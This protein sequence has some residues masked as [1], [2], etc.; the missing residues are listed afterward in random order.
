MAK[1][2]SRRDFLKGRSAADAL[3]DA[4]DEAFPAE[5]PLAS[6]TAPQGQ[7][8]LVQVSRRAMASDFVVFLNAGQY[9]EGTE[10]A[11]E[12]L[13][14]VDELEA[15]LSYFRPDSQLSRVNRWAAD[16]PVPVGARLFELLELAA[17][18][19]RQT[20]G[21]L[22]VSA[23]ALW[24]AW[25]F[26]RRAAAVPEQEAIDE[27]L[28]RVGFDH[29]HLDSQARTVSFDKPGIQLNL[30]SIGKG[31]ALDQCA[32]GL[33]AHEIEHYL[34]HGGQ[35]SVLARG[36][37]MRDEPSEHGAAPPGGWTVGLRHPLRASSR[38]GEVYL[39]D[40]ALGTSGSAAQFFRH[41]G[42]RLSHVLDPRTG[43]PAEGVLSSTVVA[44]SAAA[45]DA[46][47]TATFVMGPQRTAQFCR[48]RP[49]VAVLLVCPARRRGGV[50]LMCFNCDA[51]TLRLFEPWKECVVEPPGE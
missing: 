45:A 8:Y 26:A 12:A 32:L 34:L 1:K 22:D 4:V 44:P 39:R 6:P 30:G 9:A 33:A 15:Q 16:E 10:Q 17:E 47:S 24:Q 23:A 13:D 29:V 31:Y 40:R 48:E 11:L 49:D 14:L 2:S 19:F 20:D 21:A 35:S 28:D 3:S 46:L 50:E 36:S 18:L 42:R 51:H 41:Q 7:S 25:G 27:A 38:L 37:R 5:S 43:W